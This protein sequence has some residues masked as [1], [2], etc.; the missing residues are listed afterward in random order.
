MGISPFLFMNVEISFESKHRV[1]ARGHLGKKRTVQKVPK[2]SG[3][4]AERI[5]VI[6]MH[7][8]MRL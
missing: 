1:I 3:L 4:A 7:H 8:L 5:I 2:A 6:S